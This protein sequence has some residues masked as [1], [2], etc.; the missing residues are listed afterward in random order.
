MA[1]ALPELYYEALI[2]FTGP[3]AAS[4]WEVLTFGQTKEELRPFN[5][6]PNSGHMALIYLAWHWDLPLITVNYDQMLELAAR[7]MGLHPIICHYKAPRGYV[8][9]SKQR[10]EISIWKVHGSVDD[11]DSIRTT[12]YDI[13][14]LDASLLDKIRQLFESYKSCLIGYSG[15]D[16]DLFP[17]IADFKFPSPAFWLGPSFP[18]SNNQHRIYQRPDKFVMVKATSTKFAHLLVD[19]IPEDGPWKEALKKTVEAERRLGEKKAEQIREKLMEKLSELGI[20]HGCWVMKKLPRDSPDRLLIHGLALANISESE[21]CLKASLSYLDRF[22]EY[23]DI[24]PWKACRALIIQ[25]HSLHELSC[26]IESEKCARKAFQIAVRNGLREEQGHALASIDAAL[27]GQHL[28]RLGYHDVRHLKRVKA[29][30]TLIRMIMDSIRIRFYCPHQLD[31]QATASQI[32]ARWAYL[33]HLSRVAAI[34]QGGMSLLASRLPVLGT[35]LTT[36]IRR[37]FLAWWHYFEEKSKRNGY[38]VGVAIAHRHIK[39]LSSA[40]WDDKY[41]PSMDFYSLMS[42]SEQ[43]LFA[44][45]EAEA[46]LQKGENELAREKFKSCL[47]HARKAGNKVVMLKAL[48]G[49]YRCGEAVDI[50]EVEKTLASIQGDAYRKIEAELLHTLLKANEASEF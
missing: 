38:A 34:I 13:S 21:R 46:L 41:I 35:L 33:G 23:P 43:I 14:S 47:A 44:Y 28:P 37:I 15:C 3:E 27:R 29:W 45:D 39:R 18:T 10:K 2:E 12:L 42:A 9:A 48:I 50:D 32:R 25:A 8:I 19:H 30:Q 22:L 16:I 40:I 7:K 49:L 36:L 6:G 5:L 20:Q 17:N 24:E 4:L 26:F 1:E 31:E 11:I